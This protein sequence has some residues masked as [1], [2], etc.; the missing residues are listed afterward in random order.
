MHSRGFLYCAIGRLSTK[1]VMLSA[2]I[3]SSMSNYGSN[4]TVITDNRGI[5]TIVEA[6]QQHLFHRMLNVD[7]Y[8]SEVDEVTPGTGSRIAKINGIINTPYDET[9]FLDVD[10]EVCYMFP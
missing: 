4:I 6:G 7:E 9:L 10:T 1:E 2:T 8:V 5:D 3:L